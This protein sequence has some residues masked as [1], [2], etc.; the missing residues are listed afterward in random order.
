LALTG[1]DGE[2]QVAG[3]LT[4]EALNSAILANLTATDNAEVFAVSGSGALAV[5]GLNL[6]GLSEV[7]GEGDNDKLV[8][9]DTPTM[10]SGYVSSSGID[11]YDLGTIDAAGTA[12]LNATNN[13]D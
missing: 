5:A 9:I 1:T 3:S 13:D 8:A 11:F 12:N 4:F 2:L 6:S 7:H 10:E